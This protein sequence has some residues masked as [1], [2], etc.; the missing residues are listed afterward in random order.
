LYK[1]LGYTE[2]TKFLPAI[3]RAKESCKQI[4]Q[5]VALHFAQVSEPQKSKNQYGEI[6]GLVVNYGNFQDAGY[7]GLYGM[8]QKDIKQK[9]NLDEKR[10]FIRQYW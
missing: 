9:K 3:N 5:E 4:G 1:F 2:Y 6:L 10:K 8:R 7:F